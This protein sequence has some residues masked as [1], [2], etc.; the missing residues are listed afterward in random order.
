M[1][2]DFSDGRPARRQHE[3]LL[4]TLLVAAVGLSIVYISYCWW[5]LPSPVGLSGQP[6]SNPLPA[7]WSKPAGLLA[8]YIVS[9][10]ALLAAPFRPTVG[11]GIYMLAAWLFPIHQPM[12][13]YTQWLGFPTLVAILGAAG[14]ACYV[15]RHGP[16]RWPWQEFSSQIMLAFVGWCGLSALV[17][18]LLSTSY[19]PAL[20]FHP[21]HL[22]DAFL[23]FT[24]IRAL[25]NRDMSL[26]VIVGTMG[27]TL[28]ARAFFLQQNLFRDA[29]IAMNAAMT[30]PLALFAG[31]ISRRR[32]TVLPWWG[33]AALS[34]WMVYS[35][36]NRGAA[37]GLVVGLY[38]MIVTSKRP[39]IIL[40][41]TLVTAGLGAGVFMETSFGQRF[42]NLSDW[43]QLWTK[44]E[45]VLIWRGGVD[46][47]MDHLLVGVGP[48]NFVNEIG[49]YVPDSAYHS[50]N[51]IWIGILAET[52]PVGAALYLSLILATLGRCFQNSWLE[53]CN[54]N[55]CIFVAVSA[56]LGISMFLSTAMIVL[57]YA[58]L[59]LAGGHTSAKDRSS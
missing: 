57:P 55:R 24:I 51:N 21:R 48:G 39:A 3:R 19:H 11:I 26:L 41:C 5:V 35:V 53:G 31:F 17:G 36:E 18:W 2:A 6:R 52:G 9:V 50:S 42:Q 13:I 29:D 8:F 1:T 7:Q 44:N 23:I 33:L 32:W 25:P 43:N 27:I 22:V 54:R 14:C 56:H 40:T 15:Y 58:L 37:V 59:A 4:L 16:L 20:Q 28:L 30:T 34:L 49:N 12:W 47:A 46:M 38:A 10:L 45:R